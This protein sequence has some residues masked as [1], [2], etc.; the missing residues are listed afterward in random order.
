MTS[1]VSTIAND[2]RCPYDR[3][4][5]RFRET[6]VSCATCGKDIGRI[7][8]HGILSLTQS[9]YYYRELPRE[10][11]Q[12]LVERER[13]LDEF[14][15]LVWD[16]PQKQDAA[17]YAMDKTRATAL[18]QTPLDP[19]RR[20]LDLGCGWGT[21]GRSISGFT[22]QVVAMDLT[23]PSL[24][25]SARLA[26][27][28]MIHVH[29]G[30]GPYLP[31]KD[32]TFD[33]VILNGVLE[34]IPESRPGV[35]PW[36]A[37]LH[38]LREVLRILK[39]NGEVL[40][41]IENRISALYAMG[42]REDHSG[43]RFIS[44]LP[45]P[46]AN[47][48]SRLVRGKE[49][50]NHTYSSSGLTKIF[51]QA[52]YGETQFF[53]PWWI[54]RTP[55][56]VFPF[57]GKNYLDPNALKDAATLRHRLAN[58][59]LVLLAR[60]PAARAF[61]PSF[62]VRAGKTRLEEGFFDR[63]LQRV[64][65]PGARNE[66]VYVT[67]AGSVIGFGKR[68]SAKVGIDTRSSQLVCRDHANGERARQISGLGSYIPPRQVIDHNGHPI[69]VTPRM[70]PVK[71]LSRNLTDQIEV[72][73]ESMHGLPRSRKP[74]REVI[75]TSP[76]AAFLALTDLEQD[77]RLILDLLQD[78]IVEV[79]AVHGDFHLQQLFLVQGKLQVID[80]E[81]FSL[82]GVYGSDQWSLAMKYW[83]QQERASW[84]DLWESRILHPGIELERLLPKQG[85][86]LRD[87]GLGARVAFALRTILHNMLALE[88]PIE[89]DRKQ[90][91]QV[92][93]RIRRI[94]QVVESAADIYRCSPARIPPGST[95]VRVD[96][97]RKCPHLRGE[98]CSGISQHEEQQPDLQPDREKNGEFL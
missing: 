80:W 47:L 32:E 87:V 84:I 93:N 54:Y 94:R 3:G 96:R 49:Y 17:S 70:C 62:Y 46:L 37:Q 73:L 89:L 19:D 88:H 43:L 4:E 67:G 45:R 48:Y 69:L 14:F 38:F 91:S 97:G 79:G 78:E 71:D 83:L 29:G 92:V 52:G 42:S 82:S 12:T 8:S 22:K 90:C 28:G 81:R 44:L 6:T 33:T 21:L 98:K 25:L 27:P 65:G 86:A 51:R 1:A 58:W 23:Y 85:Q 10:E 50:R 64:E 41:G 61:V 7:D 26:R 60:C 68:Y 2:L 55:W 36:H 9:N 15:K 53:W 57:V 30:D 39:T 35:S 5:L 40:L 34:W 56:H 16:R 31:F 66:G 75:D 63:V 18:F 59:L 95:E 77:W 76:I 24:V 74:F 11:I 20:V 72:F 13:V